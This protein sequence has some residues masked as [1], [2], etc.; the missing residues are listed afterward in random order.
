MPEMRTPPSPRSKSPLVVWFRVLCDRWTCPRNNSS[1][2]PRRDRQVQLER[3]V[4]NLN[5]KHDRKLEKPVM[6]LSRM[7]NKDEV[8]Y[9]RTELESAGI[10]LENTRDHLGGALALSK[11]TLT[12]SSLKTS[13]LL[14]RSKRFRSTYAR[15]SASFVIRTIRGSRPT[16]RNQKTPWDRAHLND[17]ILGPLM[18]AV[19]TNVGLEECE[20]H[21]DAK[22]VQIQRMLRS[23]RCK[24]CGWV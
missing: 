23:E 18:Q 10:V 2:P 9:W 11:S 14:N 8:H 19:C 15:I 17:R 24:Y 22:Y 13:S 21:G 7:L 1:S 20:V 4:F 16:E 3:K 6:S 5:G 12:I